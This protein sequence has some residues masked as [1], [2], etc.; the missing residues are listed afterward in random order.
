MTLRHAAALALV[1]WYLMMP[2]LAADLDST[3][4]ADRLLPATSDLFVSL[5][6]W[7]NPSEVNM[8][9]CDSLR[10]EVRYDAP[11]TDWSQVGSFESLAACQA[12]Y[13]SNQRPLNNE[14][15]LNR[16]V[17]KMELSDEGE[18]HPSD[19]SLQI[20]AKTVEISVRGETGGMKCV[21]TDDPRLKGAK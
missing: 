11:M 17:A 6:T 2:P 21:A 5:L 7:R 1:G 10:H 20:R 15:V 14:E 4:G 9:R 16:G 12:E 18:Q 13:E 3:C 19:E 8:I